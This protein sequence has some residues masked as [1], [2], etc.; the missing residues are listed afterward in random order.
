MD[1]EFQFWMNWYGK[2]HRPYELL[3]GDFVT[4]AMLEKVSQ[5]SII[6]VNNFAFGPTL[7]QK[8]KDIFA[9]L[10]DGKLDSVIF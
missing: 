9:E 3:K 8:L 2:Q 6:F 1:K 5:A 4:E 10:R 7:D